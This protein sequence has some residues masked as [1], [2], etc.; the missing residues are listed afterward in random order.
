MNNALID[1][2]LSK[3]AGH[4]SG[5]SPKPPE[6]IPVV[7]DPTMWRLVIQQHP[8]ERSGDHYDIRL[9]DGIT[10]KAHS[11][12]TK[13]EMPGRGGKIK[14]FQTFTHTAEYADYQGPL[15]KG[16]GKTREGASVTKVLDVP[17]EVIRAD[18]NMIRFNTY[19]D[20]SPSQLLMVR[21]QESPGS[22]F[23]QN[24]GSGR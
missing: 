3:A 17:A 20:G 9:V 21:D 2:F 24:V 7:N 8:A 12:A 13:K 5:M 10:G 18:N 6:D 22:W 11:W 19:R 23:L 14:A 1:G 16:R 4:F 15:D